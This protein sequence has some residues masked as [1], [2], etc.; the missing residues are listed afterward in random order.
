VSAI[1]MKGRESTTP[2]DVAVD[3]LRIPLDP[4]GSRPL[5]LSRVVGSIRPER[6]YPIVGRRYQATTKPSN[7]WSWRLGRPALRAATLVRIDTAGN[8]LR[9]DTA[10]QGDA[11]RIVQPV[12]SHRKMV[13]GPLA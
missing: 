4:C 2:P 5:D 13:V 12:N 10:R 6:C 3:Q 1:A 11:S 9:S 8:K 7:E